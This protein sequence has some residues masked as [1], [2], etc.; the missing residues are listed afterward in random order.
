MTQFNVA[1]AKAK[2]SQLI[3]KA[4][5]GEDVIIAK[6]HKP[7]VKLVPFKNVTRRRQPGS[8]KGRVWVSKDFDAPLKD[9]A[10]YR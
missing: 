10:D 2:F 3:R 7:L 5:A 6:D 8:A 1:E 9:L 4:M